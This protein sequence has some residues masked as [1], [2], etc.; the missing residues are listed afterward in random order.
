MVVGGLFPEVP[1][2]SVGKCGD[3]VQLHSSEGQLVEKRVQNL[4][5]LIDLGRAGSLVRERRRRAVHTSWGLEV[6]SAVGV[7]AKGKA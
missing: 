6:P 7:C 1:K 4:G 5:I 3:K 2:P